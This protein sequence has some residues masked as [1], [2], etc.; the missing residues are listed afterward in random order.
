M[1][2]TDSICAVDQVIRV[3]IYQHVLHTRRT[4]VST[5]EVLAA[6]LARLQLQSGS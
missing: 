6:R 5:A 1:E 2:V 3:R 4:I